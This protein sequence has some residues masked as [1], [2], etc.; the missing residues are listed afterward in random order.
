[1]T[2]PRSLA[3]AAL[4]LGA[5]C[6]L[7]PR[8]ERPDPPVASAWSAEAGATPGAAPASTLGWRDVFKD[9]RLQAIVA[10]ALEN[11]R[12][13]RVAALNV[14]LT[15]AQYRIERADQLPSLGASG[16]ATHRHVGDDLSVTGAPM[17]TT[18]WTVGLG[19]TA[20]ELDFFGRV[21]SL[22]DAALEQ[23]LATEEARR[24]AHLSLVAEVA[25]QYLT[26]LALDDQ[27]ELARRTLEA[28][29]SSSS[30]A[31][32]T[33]EAGRT[34]ELD[35]STAEAQLQTARFNLSAAK[36]QRARAE[37]TLLLL[38][39]APLPADLPSPQPLDAQELLADLPPGVPSEVLLRRP[40]VLS[41]EHAL[42]SANAVIGAARAAFFPSISLTGFAGTSSAELSGLF[43]HGAGLWSF[44]P[45]LN[46]PIFAG[47]ALRANLDASVVRKSIQVARYER[48]IQSAFREVSDALVAKAS[49]DEQLEAQRARVA[50]EQ[51]RY[52]L[53][54]LRYARGVD[55]YL[56]VLQAQRDLFT[57]QQL[58]IQSRLARLSNL[59]LL[60]R[61]L[62]G[63]WIEGAKPSGDGGS[64]RG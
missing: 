59:I 17:T 11:N 35:V 64:P 12:D 24:T 22:S 60:Y 2:S 31:R 36:L 53:S 27:V 8:Y 56:G 40:D 57:A 48:A 21:R 15:R 63:G 19:V 54:E 29:E 6:S 10:L 3:A 16:S 9:P 14:E 32:R 47:G 50:A 39:G 7:A 4:L 43:G 38:V 18:T 62:G 26:L 58:L 52:D 51:K 41:A 30:L 45:Q 37:S 42:Q 1:M 13:L 55:S 25:T 20:F 46:L 61:A 5:G 44:A 28:V 33:F 49:L 23:F 34:S